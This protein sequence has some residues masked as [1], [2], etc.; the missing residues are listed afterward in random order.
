MGEKTFIE[1]FIEQIKPARFG[2]TLPPEKKGD[3]PIVVPPNPDIVL[4]IETAS[5]SEKPRLVKIVSLGSDF[6][7]GRG[8]DGAP[9]E[10]FSLHHI[11]NWRFAEHQP[12]EWRWK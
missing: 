3:E 11:T 5:G 9:Q 8:R 1:D 10:T 12:N 2:Y 4:R 6:F 7:V